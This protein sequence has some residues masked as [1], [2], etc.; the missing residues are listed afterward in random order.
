MRGL[1]LFG[2]LTTAVVVFIL[3]VTA[4]GGLAGADAS[5][6]G[7][8]SADVRVLSPTPD[9]LDVESG[10]FGSAARYVRLPDVTMSISDVTGRPRVQYRITVPALDIDR[11][12]S[13]VIEGADRLRIHLPDVALPPRGQDPAP[14]TYQGRVIVAV[15]S[16][17]TDRT[18]LNRSVPVRVRK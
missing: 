3:V 9:H 7:T 18:V 12:R 16:F 17:S 2:D 8:G 4:L 1:S 6:V 15:Q 5:Q 10:R 13:S 11:H 14:G